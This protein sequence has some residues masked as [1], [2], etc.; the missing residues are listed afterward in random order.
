MT[1]ETPE[2][3]L[4]EG[5]PEFHRPPTDAVAHVP[6][7]DAAPIPTGPQDW[8]NVEFSDHGVTSTSGRAWIAPAITRETLHQKGIHDD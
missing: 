8:R 7:P 2:Y 4:S 5:F 1:H 3:D 6:A